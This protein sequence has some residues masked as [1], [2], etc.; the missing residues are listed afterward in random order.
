MPKFTATEDIPDLKLRSG[1][2][3]E[4]TANQLVG[5]V[6]ACI[7]FRQMKPIEAKIKPKTQA[8]TGD[9]K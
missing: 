6:A 5:R 2:Q 8:K 9:D 4:Y 7:H 1:D 3:V